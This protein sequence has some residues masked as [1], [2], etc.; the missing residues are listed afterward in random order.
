M[1]RHLVLWSYPQNTQEACF[2][3]WD[4]HE[5]GTTAQSLR[6]VSPRKFH[7]C[8]PTLELTCRSMAPTRSAMPYTCPFHSSMFS[9]LPVPIR[10]PQPLHHRRLLGAPPTLD[11]A[12]Q[13]QTSVGSST[14]GLERLDCYRLRIFFLCNN[15]SF[16]I[17]GWCSHADW[18]FFVF[19]YCIL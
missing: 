5:I 16:G 4:G 11:D 19:V 3:D 8:S 15:K 2:S 18:F 6:D 12:G 1:P 14:E 13:L 9:F 17:L 10:T 7:P